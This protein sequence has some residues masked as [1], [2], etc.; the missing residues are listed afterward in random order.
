MKKYNIGLIRVVSFEDE[1]LL[2]LHG[3]I[4]EKCYPNLNVVSKAIPDQPFGIHDDETEMIAVP[5]IIELAKE[6]KG[7][8]GLIISC[9]GDPGVEE[10][11][12]ILDIPV[13]GAGESTALMARR[14]GEVYGVLGITKE[15]PGA[16]REILGSNIVW[17]C[18]V[19]GVVST[20]DLM[21]DKGR[22]KVIEKAVK[23]KELGAEVIALACTGMA[24]IGIAREVEEICSIP[25]IDPVIAE[26]LITLYE[27]TR[28][29]KVYE[30]KYQTI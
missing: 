15:I 14:Y 2:N 26:G 9:A 5:K 23:L 4:I 11:R 3:D 13:V 12:K 29:S 1:D 24:T 22:K 7:L 30:R 10:L 18:D 20:L 16:Y 27:V 21:S 6:W 8:D 25:V 28:K 17:T 19:D